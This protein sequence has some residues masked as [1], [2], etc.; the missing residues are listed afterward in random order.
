MVFFGLYYI[1][2]DIDHIHLPTSDEKKE[3]AITIDHTLRYLLNPLSRVDVDAELLLFWTM[4]PCQD[5]FQIA[6]HSVEL[7]SKQVM[8]GNYEEKQVCLFPHCIYFVSFIFK[9]TLFVV[10]FI[11]IQRRC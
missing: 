2:N 10:P 5:S 8:N 3:R 6:A 11:R 7:Q 1:R 9:R 4:L